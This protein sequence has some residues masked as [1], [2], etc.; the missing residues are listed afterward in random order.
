MIHKK[1]ITEYIFIQTFCHSKWPKA[2]VFYEHKI[3]K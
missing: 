1:A 3:A 2:D